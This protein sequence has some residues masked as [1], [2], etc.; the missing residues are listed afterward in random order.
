MV[1]TNKI[2]FYRI[3]RGLSQHDLADVWGKS[4]AVVQLVETGHRMANPEEQKEV[5]E[6]LNV[7]VKTLF[8]QKPKKETA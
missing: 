6:I 8:P 5:A 1:H 7:P 2:K 3:E 4:R